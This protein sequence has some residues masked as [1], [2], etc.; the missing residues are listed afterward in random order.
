M[1]TAKSIPIIIGVTGHRTI[2]EEDRPAIRAAVKTELEKLRALCPHSPLVM[3]N[4]LAEGADLLCADV[5]EELGFPIVAVL[6]RERVAYERDFSDSARERFAH[7]CARAERVL[8][9]PAAEKKAEETEERN[10]Q[11]RQAGIYVVEHS[12]VL[13]AL[14]DGGEGAAAACG[15]AAAVDFVLRGSF[16]PL[17]GVPV[18]SANN[19]AVIHIF[20]PRG[21]RAEEKAG[22]IHVL[23]N[24]TAVWELLKKTD[25]FNRLSSELAVQ[26]RRLIPGDEEKDDVL[27]R[28]EQVY[29]AASALSGRAA[30]QYRRILAALALTATVLTLAFLLYDEAQALGMILVCGAM[31]LAARRLIR[32]AAVSDCH[33]KYVEYRA[34]AEAVR[35][36]SFLYY[37]GADIQAAELFSWTQQE[38]TA[39]IM[40][41]LYALTITNSPKHSRD[42]L[43]CW[44]RQ[45]RAYHRRAGR[46][47]QH[48]ARISSRLV[49]GALILS[50]AL[51]VLAVIFELLCGGLLFQPVILVP[52]AEICRTVLKIAMGSLSAITL[53]AANYYG[54]MSLPRRG[55]DHTKMERFYLKMEEQLQQFGQTDELLTALAREEVNENGNWLSYQRDNTPDLSL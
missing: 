5:A 24:R 12:H 11:F 6:P 36:Q 53:F 49:K 32:T 23:G 17:S 52:G 22:T 9:A 28:M 50:V 47:V 42:I 10:F 21:E 7:H 18:R 54:K 55:S 33:G 4:S 14:W 29:L 13:L 35:V 3:L 44:V 8:V 41:A 38:E 30:K 2:R 1:N 20:T 15:T 45:Q 37:A 46:R 34:L 40:A 25:E 16:R 51:Y 39:W 27:K 48:D 43:D 31:L 26:K 19:E